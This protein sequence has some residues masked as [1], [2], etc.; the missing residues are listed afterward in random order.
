M[1]NVVKLFFLGLIAISCNMVNAESCN[2]TTKISFLDGTNG[3]AESLPYA[4]DIPSE[5]KYKLIY[6]IAFSQNYFVAKSKYSDCKAIT[7]RGGSSST[8]DP[9]YRAIHEASLPGL[10]KAALESCMNLGCDCEMVL[11]SGSVLVD[12]DILLSGRSVSIPNPAT[13][14]ENEIRSNQSNDSRFFKFCD[15]SFTWFGH[16]LHRLVLSFTSACSCQV[17]SGVPMN[18]IT[19]VNGLVRTC[20]TNERLQCHTG[21]RWCR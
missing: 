8:P 19:Y 20:V 3:C 12:K 21:N 17:Q 1:K 9:R 16:C 7:F 15:D 6:L 10:K 4:N 2:F 18:F 13:V 11:D 14:I 5:Q